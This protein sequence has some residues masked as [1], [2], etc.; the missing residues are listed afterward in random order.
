MIHFYRQNIPNAADHQRLLN[1][2][3][4][5]SKKNDKSKINWTEEAIEA[6][7]QYKEDIKTQYFSNDVSFAL[8]TDAS[9]TCAGAVL[10]QR[11][12]GKWL[13]L[14]FF[15]K[16]FS[17]AQVKY[18]TYDRELLSIYMAMKHFRKTFEG[19]I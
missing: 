2:Y 18:S 6:F 7:N 9:D 12:N 3:L 11:I 19:K 1:Q 8:M 10:Q 4:H 14:G 17:D 5:Q 13:S 16:K 15:S